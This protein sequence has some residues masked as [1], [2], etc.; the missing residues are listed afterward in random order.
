MVHVKV[1]L[2]P[3]AEQDVARVAVVGHARIAQRTNKHGVEFPQEVVA[4]RRQGS[5]LAR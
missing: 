2:E 4:I 5:L 1:E 3:R